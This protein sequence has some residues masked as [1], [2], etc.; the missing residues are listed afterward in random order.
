ME[1]Q[2]TRPRRIPV[3]IPDL[4]D[5][6]DEASSWDASMY[7]DLDT[8]AVVAISA[9]INRELEA[10]SE[11]LASDP[12]EGE[13]YRLAFTGALEQRSLPAWV[14]EQLLQADQVERG[15]GTRFIELPVADSSQSYEYM[16]DFIGT[17]RSTRLQERLWDVIRG[18]GAFRRF[19]NALAEH[20]TEQER[21]FAFKASRTRERAIEWLTAQGIQ[22]TENDA[23]GADASTQAPTR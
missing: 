6:L 19:K 14:R 7:L 10:L 15:L 12:T 20:P 9:E 22:P 21:W 4:V 1:P 2:A 13:E 17:V 11:E 8:G 16:Q 5:A 23:M 3:N 18:R